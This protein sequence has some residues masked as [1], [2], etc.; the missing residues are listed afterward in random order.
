MKIQEFRKVM[1]E[2]FNDCA[3]ILGQK[4]RIRHDE[5]KDE[6]LAQFYRIAA[7]RKCSPQ[8]AV[9]RAGLDKHLT[10]I[11][12]LIENANDGVVANMNHWD[13]S[14]FDAINYLVLLRATV[15]DFWTSEMEAKNELGRVPNEDMRSG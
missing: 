8:D 3:N 4:G 10:I 1:S 7:M 12:Q 9:S 15:I 14:I 6:R 2:T 5:S 11:Y 13:D